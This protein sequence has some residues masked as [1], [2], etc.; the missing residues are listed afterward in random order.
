MY[1]NLNNAHEKIS[2]HYIKYHLKPELN[3]DSGNRGNNR[4]ENKS[5]LH[6]EF[7]QT[8]EGKETDQQTKKTEIESRIFLEKKKE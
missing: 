7:D 4:D 2:L 8:S 5:R 6:P 3:R 1:Y